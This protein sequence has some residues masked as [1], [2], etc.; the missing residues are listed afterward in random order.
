MNE[1]VL[2]K[3]RRRDDPEDIP[4]W[5]EFE[6][7][8]EPGMTVLDALEAI[9]RNS[10]TTD[11]NATAPVAFD[12]CCGEGTCGA[13]AMLING[14]IALACRSFLDELSEPIALEALTK[15]PAIRDLRVDRSRLA[16]ALISAQAWVAI[17]GLHAR[18]EAFRWDPAEA[19]RAQVLSNCILCGACAEAC[20]QV[21]ERS[22]FSGAFLFAHVEPLQGHPIGRYGADGRLEALSQ[23]GGIADCMGAQACEAFCPQRIPLTESIARISGQTVR[24]AMRR[25]FRA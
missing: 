15:F 16:Q 23:R 3:V 8:V 21:N 19:I 1:S 14:R 22:P 11:G 13:C 9:R 17:D 4:Y 6:I 20:P 12:A 7:A 2:I 24:A 10:R 18:G 25:L 5:E